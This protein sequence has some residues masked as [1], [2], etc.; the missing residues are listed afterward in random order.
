MIIQELKF[1]ILINKASGKAN[2]GLNLRLYFLDNFHLPR[3]YNVDFLFP[4][5]KDK[6]GFMDC[7]L[8]AFD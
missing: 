1:F 7:G 3:V 6:S 8:V 5:G 2:K 4:E